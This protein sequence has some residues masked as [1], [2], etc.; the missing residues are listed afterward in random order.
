M[1]STSD[2]LKHFEERLSKALSFTRSELS[3]IRAGKA[4]T[5][6]LHSVRVMY[7]GNITPLTQIASIIATDAHTLEIKPWELSMLSEIEKA[8][9]NSNLGFMPQNTGEIIRIVVP[10]MSEERR[11]SLV[12][13]AKQ[14]AEKCKVT[15]RSIRQECRDRLKALQKDGR[16]EDIIKKVES[17]I[18]NMTNDG[19]ETVDTMLAAKEKNLMEV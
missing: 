9:I 14:E 2:V 11:I 17:D 1:D 18:Q 13:M 4:D 12:K 8:I 16:S 19:I 5:D 3:K 15:I 7:Y 10:S 6:M